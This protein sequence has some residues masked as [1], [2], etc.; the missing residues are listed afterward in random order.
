MRHYRSNT[1]AY[2][3]KSST[4]LRTSRR[5]SNRN[6]EDVAVEAVVCTEEITMVEEGIEAVGAWEGVE[7]AEA[8]GG[9][10]E[11]WHESD[12]HHCTADETQ[13]AI[14]AHEARC[15]ITRYEEMHRLVDLQD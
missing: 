1:F 5:I 10:V 12:G 8:G 2:P 6:A 13:R 11:P 14:T 4:W 3:M 9:V 15:L 7:E